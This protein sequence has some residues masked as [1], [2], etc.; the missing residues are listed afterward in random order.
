MTTEN[1][2][3]MMRLLDRLQHAIIAE[4]W[5]LCW[6]LIRELKEIE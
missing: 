3:R 1:Y 5:P 6:I 2:I 4:R